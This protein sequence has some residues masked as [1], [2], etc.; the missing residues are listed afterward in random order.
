MIRPI[1]T[2]TS[3]IVPSSEPLE[4]AEVK[5]VLRFPTSSEDSLLEGWMAASRAL[6]EQQTGRQVAPATWELWLDAS[7][8][9]RSIELPYPPLISVLSVEYVDGAG[10]LQTFDAENYTVQAPQGPYC[11]PGRI[12]LVGSAQWPIP[13]MEPA[14]TQP[15]ALRITFRAGYVADPAGSPEVVAIPDLITSAIYLLIGNFHKFRS[16]VYEKDARSTEALQIPLGAASIMRT[17][18]LTALPLMRPP[19]T[20]TS[21]WPGASWR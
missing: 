20:W 9:D 1:Q 15:G 21:D 7:P 19:S 16:E 4:L 14:L 5:K 17:F 3:L 6:F 12:T 13:Q 2:R 8:C 10:D 18:A 11:A